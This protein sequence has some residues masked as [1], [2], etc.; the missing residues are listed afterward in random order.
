MTEEA[1]DKRGTTVQLSIENNQLQHLIRKHNKW[2]INTLKKNNF[3]EFI[4]NVSR[5]LLVIMLLLI[6]YATLTP[7]PGTPSGSAPYLHFVGMAWV[8]FL[9]CM[10]FNDIKFR[11]SAVIFVFAY[12]SLMELFQHY[13]PYR[14][15]TWDDV[16]LN[17][18]GSVAGVGVFLLIN[19]IGLKKLLD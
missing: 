1:R 17:G 19:F 4:Q 2:K 14:H 11:V 18:V 15:G 3:F 8:A 10:S 5:I 13:L 9:A 6:P 16:F 7:D 12:S